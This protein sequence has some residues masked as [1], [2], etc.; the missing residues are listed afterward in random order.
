[1]SPFGKGKADTNPCTRT[2]AQSYSRRFNLEGHCA[3]LH[4][5]VLVLSRQLSVV[6][7]FPFPLDEH[8][9]LSPCLWTSKT[10]FEITG[11]GLNYEDAELNDENHFAFISFQNDFPVLFGV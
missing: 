11:E 6:L 5:W 8:P 10:P 2:I 1:M 7:C 3:P 9:F 4:L